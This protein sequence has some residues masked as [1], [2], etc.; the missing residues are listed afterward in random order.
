MILAEWVDLSPPGD[1]RIVPARAMRVGFRETFLAADVP[2]G[3]DA[4][5][6]L[7]NPRLPLH[8]VAARLHVDLRDV[9]VVGDSERD[10]LAAA[11]AGAS[12]YLVRTGKGRW[13]ERKL[14]EPVQTFDD[15]A[16]FVDHLLEHG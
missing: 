10:L 16:A 5:E 6:L 12:P 4:R 9:P 13:T 7:A 3:Q 15:L 11:S 1:V 8:D 2:S 14:S